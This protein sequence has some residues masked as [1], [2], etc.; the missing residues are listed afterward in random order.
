MGRAVLLRA[1]A[2][3]V[4]CSAALI[5]SAAPGFS[6]APG[7]F[8]VTVDS[9]TFA[10]RTSQVCGFDVYRHDVGT[11]VITV[12]TDS[13]GSNIVREL[14]RDPA[15]K[16]TWFSPATG[17]SFS[18]P[19]SASLHVDYSGSNVGDAAVGRFTGV[20][21]GTPHARSSGEVVV[22]M[23]IVGFV[24]VGSLLVPDTDQT[25]PPVAVHGTFPDS[26]FQTIEARCA[27]LAA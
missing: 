15:F 5:G 20:Q 10:P 9:T 6:A 11:E 22:P 8:T 25:G 14:D 4:C 21:N 26:S 3:T 1:V 13:T 7:R 27:A 18:Y 23:V 16:T 2:A 17:K 12:F 19:D 24:P